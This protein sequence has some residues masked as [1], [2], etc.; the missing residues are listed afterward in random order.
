MDLKD[1]R[2]RINQLVSDLARSTSPEVI[3]MREIFDLQYEDAKE[4]LV[5]ADGVDLTRVQGEARYLE[6]FTKQIHAS[7]ALLRSN[8]G[9]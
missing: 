9:A 6:K 7:A 8:K 3:W 5:D 1:R 4:R 2:A